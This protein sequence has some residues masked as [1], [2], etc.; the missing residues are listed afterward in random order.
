MSMKQKQFFLVVLMCLLVVFITGCLGDHT[1]GNEN[2]TISTTALPLTVPVVSAPI[3]SVQGFSSEKEFLA[4]SEETVRKFE[5]S[6]DQDLTFTG[7]MNVSYTDL[8]KFESGNSSFW[9]NKITGRVQSAS[10]FESGSKSQKEIIDLEQGSEIAESYAKEKFPELWNSS[11]KKGVKQ[12]LKSIN[13]GGLD[14]SFQYSWLETFTN[15]L[16][17]SSQN[18]EIPGL[19]F[20]M[21]IVSPYT[22]NVTRYDETYMPYDSTISLTPSLTQD[23]AKRYAE[24]HFQSD[25]FE[26]IKPDQITSPGL[27]MSVDKNYHQH[28]TWSFVLT[29]NWSFVLTQK[30]MNGYY[31]KGF[32]NIDAHNGE[33]VWYNSIT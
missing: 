13:D 9:I 26:N 5:N 25:G 7:I 28:L 19:N 21:I 31:K 2:Q 12:I 10:W 33:V 29:Q 30:E 4:Q 3:P 6:S 24:S 16:S 27:S 1:A 11:D 18:S 15:P 22:G 32:A 20:V 17:N 8:Y 23:E 14:R